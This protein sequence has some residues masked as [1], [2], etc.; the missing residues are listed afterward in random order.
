MRRAARFRNVLVHGYI[1]VSDEVV[2]SRLGDL[3][4]L[5]NFVAAV[6]RFVTEAPGNGG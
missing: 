5:E 4:D 1:E 6:A 3:T 2:V